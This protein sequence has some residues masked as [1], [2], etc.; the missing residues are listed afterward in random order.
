MLFI[1]DTKFKNLKNVHE[2]WRF[3]KNKI[4][5]VNVILQSN[6]NSKLQTWRTRRK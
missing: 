3:I 5:I 4:G 1:M 6:Y 2:H